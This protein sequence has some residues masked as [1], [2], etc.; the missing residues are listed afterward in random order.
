MLTGK[1]R[2]YLR[3]LGQRLAATLQVGREGVTAAVVEQAD[4]QLAAHELIKIRVSEHAPVSRHETADTLAARTRADVVQ[5]LGRTALLY[6]RR[7]EDPA[8]VLPA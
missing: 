6:R 8:I 5:V 2:R 3:S 7:P 1:Q 4:T